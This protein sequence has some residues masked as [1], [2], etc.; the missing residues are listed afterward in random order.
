MLK[1]LPCSQ[2]GSISLVTVTSHVAVGDV[3]YGPY[4]T[5]SHT[6]PIPTAAGNKNA[7]VDCERKVC[8]AT[9]L[10]ESEGTYG[11]PDT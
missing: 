1:M 4:V 5:P 3:R 9:K 10:D 8:H 11:I 7:A 2:T 6:R